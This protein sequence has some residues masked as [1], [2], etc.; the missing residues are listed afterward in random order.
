MSPIWV[1][2]DGRA[3][4]HH[5]DALAL[6]LTMDDAS[7]DAIITD[8]PYSSGGLYRGD[9]AQRTAIKYTD[10]KRAAVLP[11][12][13]GDNRDQRSWL[14]WC[15]LWLTEAHRVTRPG[16]RTACKASDGRRARTASCDWRQLPTLTDAV[17]AGGWLWRGVLPWI[18]PDP[19][20]QFGRFSQ[21]AEFI[22]WATHGPRP[23]VG[24]C[25]PGWWLADA[26]HGRHHQTEKP[27]AVMRDL[28]K[29]CPKDGTILDPFAGSATTGIAALAE[30]RRFIGIENTAAYADIAA[31]RL[32]QACLQPTVGQLDLF[33]TRLEAP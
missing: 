31:A 30:G 7:I 29:A 33:P 21:A 10:A 23:L 27:M 1:S 17:Q 26:P 12:F 15:T 11:D 20:P 13:S 6:M 16:A 25:M 14:I 3:T 22:V 8:P 28:V 24:A 32:G 19:R 5:G 2:D 4:L 18:K 9:R